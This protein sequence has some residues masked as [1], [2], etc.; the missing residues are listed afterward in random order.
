MKTVQLV[1]LIIAGFLG[2][3]GVLLFAG[4]FPSSEELSYGGEVVVWG[5]LSG[6]EL[7]IFLAEFNEKHET[8]YSVSYKSF[9][10]EVFEDELLEA[11]ASNTGPD[12]A[13]LPSSWVFKHSN[14]FTEIPYENYP[15]RD[16]RDSFVDGSEIFLTKTGVIALP[17]YVD[18]LVMYWNKDIYNAAAV[19]RPPK[20]WGE[21]L[22][23]SENITQ[24][25]RNANIS[26]SALALGTFD[27]IKYAKE[28]LVALI[29][30]T[31]AEIVS[32]YQDGNKDVTSSALSSFNQ[33][34]SAVIKFY[35][36]FSDPAKP[37]YSWNVSLPNSFTAFTNGTLATYFSKASDRSLIEK[38][39]PHLNFDVAVLPQRDLSN[40]NVTYGDFYGLAVLKSSQNP[41]TAFRFVFDIL[42]SNEDVSRISNIAFLPP[43]KREILIAGNLNPVMSVFYNSSIISDTFLDPSYDRTNV[44]FKDMIN[45]VTSGRSSEEKAV[46]TAHL[47]LNNLIF[48][49]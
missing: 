8:D 3:L 43:A 10:P 37:T 20:V 21:F 31:G 15:E 6:T 12:V 25:D 30:Q 33:A 13:M 4:F 24:S 47:E 29:K 49:E 22:T 35:T 7:D 41:N 11:L 45:S 5:T 46:S 44:I 27:N 34:I 16:F 36:Q 19:A 28:V 32:V 26:R 48:S 14:K 42:A 9:R 40:K 17:L 39:N 38:I 23:V 2:V 1:V 18:P